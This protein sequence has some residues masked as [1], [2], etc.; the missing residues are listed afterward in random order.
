MAFFVARLLNT[1]ESTWHVDAEFVRYDAA[2][3]QQNL[4]DTWLSRLGRKLVFSFSTW[5]FDLSKQ[6]D[7]HPM[8]MGIAVG[9]YQLAQWSSPRN[10]SPENVSSTVRSLRPYK[11]SISETEPWHGR[12]DDPLVEDDTQEIPSGYVKIAIENGPFTVDLLIKDGDFP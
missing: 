3:E 1:S 7:I 8:T 2:S 4:E 11:R 5:D 10:L 9:C 12:C 6:E